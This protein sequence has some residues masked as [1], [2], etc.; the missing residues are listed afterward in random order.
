MNCEKCGAQLPDGSQLCS[1]C[2]IKPG[3]DQAVI[4]DSSHPQANSALAEVKIRHKFVTFWLWL[5][6]IIGVLWGL[7]C[8]CLAPLMYF[9]KMSS[10]ATMLLF[11]AIMCFVS[12][13]AVYKIL[14]WKKRGFYAYCI[15]EAILFCL[16]L[17]TQ[18]LM[19]QD[20]GIGIIVMQ[21][22][23][24]VIHVLLFLALLQL[25]RN[26]H[27]KTTWDQMK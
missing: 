5:Q 23:Y 7:L 10:L 14:K 18:Q 15:V 24:F 26:A 22:L 19:M 25:L 4:A 27:G 13:I 2:D 3:D 1:S 12:A 20:S 16:A 6:M 9:Y 21:S 17:R 8:L 11:S